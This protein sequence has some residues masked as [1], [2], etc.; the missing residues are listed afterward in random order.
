MSLTAVEQRYPNL[1]KT[2][3]ELAE[4]EKACREGMDDAVSPGLCTKIM[5]VD[6]TTPLS[7]LPEDAP[8]K[9]CSD[10][11]KFAMF[12]WNLLD[13]CE[14]GSVGGDACRQ[15]DVLAAAEDDTLAISAVGPRF[16]HLIGL[17]CA[18][19]NHGVSSWLDRGDPHNG[20]IHFNAIGNAWKKL[21]AKPAVD[22][23]AEGI[24][25]ELR[26]FAIT[27]CEALQRYLKNS[28]KHHGPYANAFTF[29]FMVKTRKPSASAAA[30]SAK[31]RKTA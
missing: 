28:K 31:R 7:P 22:L 24:S 25:T 12:V 14:S 21:L 17:T 8:L 23:V 10:A 29:N 1:Y 3:T 2:Y 11:N 5:G 18:T 30:S 27:W 19:V 4:R 13:A 6:F 15:W 9:T 16:E 20:K 26:A